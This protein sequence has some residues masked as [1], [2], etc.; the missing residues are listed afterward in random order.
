[1]GEYDDDDAH[2]A[3]ERARDHSA[4]FIEFANIVQH[5]SDNG[6][7]DHD[8]I[9]YTADDIDG[10]EYDNNGN[11][12]EP[13][14]IDI[15]AQ[16]V[17]AAY[18]FDGF[19]NIPDD[20]EFGSNAVYHVYIGVQTCSHYPSAHRFFKRVPSSSSVGTFFDR[21]GNVYRPGFPDA[22]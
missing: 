9:D 13:I 4:T 17:C 10:A 2:A 20:Y 18:E 19:D 22:D 15:L 21:D 7:A 1:M 11:R 12:V 14:D 6:T 3:Y 5:Y 8:D 16:F